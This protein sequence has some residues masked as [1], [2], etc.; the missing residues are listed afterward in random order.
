MDWLTKIKEFIQQFLSSEILQKIVG[1]LTTAVEWVK[2]LI[3]WLYGAVT[4]LFR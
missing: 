4:G 3:E 2:K 1:L